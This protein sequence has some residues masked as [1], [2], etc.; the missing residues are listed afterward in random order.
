MVEVVV[1]G[2]VG[3]CVGKGDVNL[4]PERCTIGLKDCWNFFIFFSS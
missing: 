4:P 2:V 3:V 1:V